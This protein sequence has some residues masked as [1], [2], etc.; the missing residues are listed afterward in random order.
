[1]M[2]KDMKLQVISEEREKISK[3]KGATTEKKVENHP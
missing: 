1:M 3:G 2:K